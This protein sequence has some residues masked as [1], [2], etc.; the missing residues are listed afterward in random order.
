MNGKRFKVEGKVWFGNKGFCFDSIVSYDDKEERAKEDFF[1]KAWKSS[2]IDIIDSISLL[3]QKYVPVIDAKIED[4]KKKQTK[5]WFSLKG[6]SIGG[7]SKKIFLNKVVEKSKFQGNQPGI[8]YEKIKHFSK[9]FEDRIRKQ[10]ENLKNQ[11]YEIILDDYQL[12][13]ASRLV[14]GLGAGHVLET[15]L[16]LHHIFGIPYIPASA[17][18]GV[19]RMVSFWEIVE[20]NKNNVKDIE[21][22]IKELQEQ[23]Y[24]N[25]LSGSDSEKILKHKLL[26]G[27]KNFKGLLVFL[28]AYPEI[29]NNQQ[30]FELDV[31]TPHYQGY[32]TKNQVPGDWE[33]PNPIV[34]LTVKKGIT[35]CFNVLF[36]KYRAEEILRDDEFPK[37]A[38]EIIK[39]WIDN[40]S[41]L[42]VGAEEILR[43]D[44]FPKN[45]KKWVED[46]LTEFGI[47]AKT[48]LGYGIFD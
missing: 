27:A 28:D 22:Y 10:K 25:E 12:K 31:M 40:L 5:I 15:S 29:Q 34:F 41:K 43:D 42:S 14:V 4:T 35:F 45:V 30:I 26:F 36:D 21:K 47:G 2:N 9:I 32:Y 37:K 3:F 38:K 33:N 16:T 8:F 17:L 6:E 44:E 1:D 24:D 11:Q 23:L 13:T 19:V 48:R 20:N 39:E 18:K 7:D 46:A